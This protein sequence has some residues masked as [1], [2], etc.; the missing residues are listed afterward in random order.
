VNL[1]TTVTVG[2]GAI[3]TKGTDPIASDPLNWLYQKIM[4]SGTAADKA[5]QS[6][7]A[8]G[9]LGAGLSITID[10][11]GGVLEDRFGDSLALARVKVV[12]VQNLSASGV[13]NVAGTNGAVGGGTIPV[14]AGGIL[15]IAAP[16]ATAYVATSGSADIISITNPG[17]SAVDYRVLIIGATA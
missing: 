4:E 8:A 11:I 10:V 17:G 6:Y 7:H 12:L 2:L 5:D 3:G 9:S 16:D 15:L 13:L 14:R 1:K